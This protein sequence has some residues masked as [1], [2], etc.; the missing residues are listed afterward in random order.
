MLVAATPVGLLLATLV[1]VIIATGSLP[2]VMAIFPTI[3]AAFIAS[4]ITAFGL[5]VVLAVIAAIVAQRVTVTFL[6]MHL[7]FFGLAVGLRLTHLLAFLPGA[8]SVAVALIL[9]H[10]LTILIDRLV[11]LSNSRAILMN[12]LIKAVNAL[13]VLLGGLTI[14]RSLLTIERHAGRRTIERAAL[15]AA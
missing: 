9:T 4:V 10:S 15:T 6:L 1:A 8:R 2:L 5:T 13:R 14:L 11:V 12:I 7:M 3:G